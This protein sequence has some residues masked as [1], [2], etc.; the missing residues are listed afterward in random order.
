MWLLTCG[1]GSVLAAV[2]G[3]L[4]YAVV[5]QQEHLQPNIVQPC[6][7]LAGL[8]LSGTTVRATK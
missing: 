3:L 8:S 6:T 4:P 7:Q 5:V 2:F 1:S